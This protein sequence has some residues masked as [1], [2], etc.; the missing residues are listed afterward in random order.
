MG[1]RWQVGHAHNEKRHS[2]LHAAATRFVALAVM[3]RKFEKFRWLL[4]Q[5]RAYAL[6]SR[7]G[8]SL[9]GSSSNKT[10]SVQRSGHVKNVTTIREPRLNEQQRHR[11]NVKAKRCPAKPWRCMCLMHPCTISYYRV[12]YFEMH[13]VPSLPE[14]PVIASSLEHV[15]TPHA[16][17]RCSETRDEENTAPG[18][19]ARCRGTLA[20]TEHGSTL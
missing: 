11:R 9:N 7:I 19:A 13:I 8:R 18:G 12:D 6:G 4:E 15:V 3:T 17:G 16:V 1:H 14:E 10:V 20:Q 2:L 5:N